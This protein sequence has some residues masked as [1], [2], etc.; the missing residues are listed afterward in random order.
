MLQKD[1]KPAINPRGW[2]TISLFCGI[3]VAKL[4]SA[5]DAWR[6]SSPIWWLSLAI[7]IFFLVSA[8][9]IYRNRNKVGATGNRLT[10]FRRIIIVALIGLTG[11]Y[12]YY[13]FEL[14]KVKKLTLIPIE[15][16]NMAIVNQ[17]SELLGKKF[18]FPVAVAPPS[19]IKIEAFNKKRNQIDADQVVDKWP[20]PP[21]DEMKILMTANDLY[22]S[23]SKWNFV[24]S[25]TRPGGQVVMASTAQ[26]AWGQAS[27]S[28]MAQRLYRSL[29]RTIGNAVGLRNSRTCAMAF[30]NNVTELDSKSETYCGSDETRMRKAGLLK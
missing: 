10:K 16:V 9:Q 20:L 30:A 15:G 27:E 28:Q 23:S 2:V 17:V 3:G 4:F 6:P 22:S 7:G 13:P 5:Y 8:I 18:A 24:F 12:M 11:L 21:T 25:A 29:L 1:T 26:M 19:Q 14:R